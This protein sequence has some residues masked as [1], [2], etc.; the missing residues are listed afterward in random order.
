MEE[1]RDFYY[2]KFK[3]VKYDDSAYY[4]CM[5]DNI[6]L[7]PVPLKIFDDIEKAI[8]YKHNKLADEAYQATYM[9]DYYEISI[10]RL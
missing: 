9:F 3:P 10:E 2:I 7:S 8:E 1:N 4:L 6:H 5:G